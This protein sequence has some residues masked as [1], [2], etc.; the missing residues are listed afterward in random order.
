MP[1]G[2][3][4]FAGPGLPVEDVPL[5]VVP[6]GGV[7]DWHGLHLAALREH[8]EALLGV[9]EVAELD[10]LEGALAD[11]LAE[12]QVEA[13][14]VAP[15]V[16]GE[17]RPLLI[18]AEDRPVDGALAGRADRPGRVAV[19]PAA[20]DSPL[21]EPLQ[22]RNVLRPGAGRLFAPLVVDELLEAFGSD[23]RLEVGGGHALL[24]A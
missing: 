10:A 22:D 4:V 7:D 17:D 14:P 6:E 16:G 12:E 19:E 20:Q 18:G 23:R 8:G 24:S 3:Q 11:P 5:E 21:K 2:E 13:E 9:V 15:V 1:A